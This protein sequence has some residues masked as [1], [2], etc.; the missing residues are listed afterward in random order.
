M[1]R[2]CL[3]WAQLRSC[4]GSV[5]LAFTS[6]YVR[7][8]AGTLMETLGIGSVKLISKSFMRDLDY[9]RH[10]KGAR[11]L[12][13]I[14]RIINVKRMES[15]RK[16]QENWLAVARGFISRILSRHISVRKS[17]K[18]F[19][20][21]YKELDFMW[22]DKKKQKTKELCRRKRSLAKKMYDLHLMKSA[23][24]RKYRSGGLM[25]SMLKLT[26]WLLFDWTRCR[27]QA[28]LLIYVSILT[29]NIRI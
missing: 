25:P 5:L 8:A 22:Q 21:D 19:R 3:C 13:E 2:T 7:N 26:M 28:V 29:H 27:P 1:N 23:G 10:E 14:K 15:W 11:H 17:A 9:G 18:I 4:L 12:V 6:H 16:R 24:F 20:R